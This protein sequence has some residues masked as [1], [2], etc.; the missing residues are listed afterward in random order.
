MVMSARKISGPVTEPISLA[1]A[2][3]YLR[4][5]VPGFNG[6][7]MQDGLLQSFITASRAAC[8][9]VLDKVIGPQVFVTTL[10]SFAPLS[11][12]AS[13][14][15]AGYGYASSYDYEH[16]YPLPTRPVRSIDLIEYRVDGG[17]YATLSPSVYTLTANGGLVLQY[18]QSWPAAGYGHD[19]VRITYTAGMGYPTDG[20]LPVDKV[21][22]DVLTAMRLLIG[23]FWFN[24]NAIVEGHI[25][26]EL[27]L[28]VKA[29]LAP[30][31]A[32]IGV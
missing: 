29:L 15:V 31:R 28:G 20:A 14:Y 5:D 18:G 19:S 12:D 2:R 13:C 10:R 16:G 27:P 4:Q 26:E 23:H 32:S 22:Q 30:N 9:Q 17:S 3:L 8:E 24:R 6:D 11:A 21:D 25:V 1:E 7:T